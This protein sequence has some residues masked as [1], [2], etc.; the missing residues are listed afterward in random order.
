MDDNNSSHEDDLQDSDVDMTETKVKDISVEK[1]EG[2]L[3]EVLVEGKGYEKPQNGDKVE[4]H[5]TGSLEDGT[6][7]DSSV[8]RGEKFSFTLGK[9]EVIKGWDVAVKTMKRGEKAKVTLKPE[10]A[11]GERGS[12]PKIPPNSTLI[13]E[14]E[15]FDWRMEDLTKKK[16][17]G[18]RKRILIDGEGYTSPNEGSTVVAHIAGKYG[19]TIFEERDVTFLLGEGCEEKIIEGVEIAIGKMKK[20]EKATVFIKRDYAWGSHIPEQFNA[21]PQDYEEVIYQVE[22]KSFE[23]MK[24]NWEMDAN[25]RL[26]QAEIAKNKGTNYFKQGKY[27]LG[28][29][30]YKRIVKY[31]GPPDNGDFEDTANRDKILLAGYLNLSLSYLKLNKP[32]EAIKNCNLALDMDKQNEKALF[33]RAQAYFNV[34][35]FDKSMNDYEQVLQLDKNNK[36]AKN[37]VILCKNELKNELEKEK[38]MYKNMFSMFAEKDEE[39]ERRLNANKDVWNELKDENKREFQENVTA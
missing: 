21:I 1:N 39:R 36:A 16:D 14:I 25:E 38:K 33:R 8:E 30:Q 28:L 20:G 2:V 18:V 15:L 24:E 32:L 12:P 31:I 23:K 37:G 7:F 13:F 29:K 11:Y 22:L 35:E 5:Y 10:Y 26:E 3:K 27:A 34:K 9:G 6:I 4:V 19:E 17:G